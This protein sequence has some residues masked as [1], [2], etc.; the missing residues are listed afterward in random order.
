[1]MSPQD[2]QILNGDGTGENLLGLYPQATAYVQPAGISM[3]AM[4]RIDKL[5]LALLQASLGLYPSDAIV[6]SETD[7]A[8]IEL[9]KDSAG[10]YIFANPLAMAGPVLWGKRVVPT[11]SMTVGNFLVGA[12]KIAATL[13]DRLTPEVL[14]SSE[15]ADDF[16]KNL[17]TMRA[18][19]RLGLAVKRPS[20][21]IKGSY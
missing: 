21:L 7:W 1:M 10:G 4:T 16:E 20:A 5:R 15:N 6:T 17:F 11:N 14:I 18:E 19:E 3:G 9:T 12:F 8:V 2:A 13:Y